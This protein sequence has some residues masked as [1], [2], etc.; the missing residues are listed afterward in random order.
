MLSL[1]PPRRK[2]AAPIRRQGG[3]CIDWCMRVWMGSISTF[4]FQSLRPPV[5]PSNS[6]TYGQAELNTLGFLD[7]VLGEDVME[8]L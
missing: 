1:L 2:H 6:A 3:G 7:E 8:W 4:K 5:R